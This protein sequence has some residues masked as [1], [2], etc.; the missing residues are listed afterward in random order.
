MFALILRWFWMP[1]GLHLCLNKKPDP[2]ACCQGFAD[3]RI[4]ELHVRYQGS[5][6]GVL[7]A[8]C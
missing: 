1:V 4:P 2:S 6:F 3:D 7:T 8:G 5:Y